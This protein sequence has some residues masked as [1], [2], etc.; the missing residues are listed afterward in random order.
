M[1]E[2]H[3]EFVQWYDSISVAHI[4]NEAKRKV[5]KVEFISGECVCFFTNKDKKP[6]TALVTNYTVSRVH[7]LRKQNIVA[8]INKDRTGFIV[9]KDQSRKE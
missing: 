9:Y 5:D 6:A 8:W 2:I 1:T 4:D 3:D 7:S